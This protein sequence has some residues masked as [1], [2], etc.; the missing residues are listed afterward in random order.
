M[1]NEKI[2]YPILTCEWC[3]KEGATVD[4][5]LINGVIPMHQEKCKDEFV[6]T[7]KLKGVITP[8]CEIGF[9]VG[10]AKTP[11]LKFVSCNCGRSTPVG[12][13]WEICPAYDPNFKQ[14]ELNV[15]CGGIKQL[16][17]MDGSIPDKKKE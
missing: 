12:A 14:L 16:K 8:S 3:K 7:I 4:M 10:Q 6:G 9:S 13:H 1:D 2:E 5:I 17:L 11:A 15:K